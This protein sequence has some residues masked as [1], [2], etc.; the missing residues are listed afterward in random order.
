MPQ[1]SHG[2]P[3]MK[4]EGGHIEE[5]APDSGRREATDREARDDVEITGPAFDGALE[6]GLVNTEA[7]M[8]NPETRTIS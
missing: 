3:I 2:Y 5:A 1:G 7:R 8:M 4:L 6:V